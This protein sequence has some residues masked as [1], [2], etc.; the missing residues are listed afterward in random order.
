[1][2]QRTVMSPKPITVI[3]DAGHDTNL[4]TGASAN[5]LDEQTV[6]MDP[7]DPIHGL[8][9]R[10]VHLC[11]MKGIKTYLTRQTPNERLGYDDR[12]E[13]LAA[14]G[15]DYLVS[16]HCNASGDVRANGVEI[17]YA[18]G[19]GRSR[20]FA[21]TVEKALKKKFPTLIFRGVKDDTKTK[22]KVNGLLR[23]GQHSVDKAAILIEVGFLTNPEDAK[24]LKSRMFRQ[25]FVSTVVN[26]LT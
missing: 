13:R 12:L 7:K 17:F 18:I 15:G 24:L 21:E 3:W 9:Q 4:N 6:T 16:F 26:C 1:M 20:K 8:V 22:R 5:G 14:L 19:D 10:A 11:H 23:I 25:D 2:E